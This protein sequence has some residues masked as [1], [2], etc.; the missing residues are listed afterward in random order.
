MPR[1]HWMPSR[2]S[3]RPSSTKS[4]TARQAPPAMH[5]SGSGVSAGIVIGKALLIRRELP[6]VV[7]VELTPAQVPAEIRRFK[8]ALVASE[9][10]LVALRD[11]VG[12]I[13]GAKEA[14]I[15]DA[16]LMLV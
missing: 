12:E 6:P 8:R 10:Q 3:S 11:R 5:L 1:R 14:S 16:H 2:N 13:I 15:F 4:D 9:K 7:E